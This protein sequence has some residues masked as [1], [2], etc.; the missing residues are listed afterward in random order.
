MYEKTLLLVAY[1]LF[2][3]LKIVGNLKNITKTLSK[4][5]TVYR[6]KQQR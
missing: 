2:I 5:R 4:D 1:Y 3:I 6:Q